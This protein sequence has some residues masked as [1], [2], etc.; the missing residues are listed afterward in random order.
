MFFFVFVFFFFSSRRRHTRCC[1]VTGVQTCALPIWCGALGEEV[2]AAAR[3]GRG[4]RRGAHFF[5]RPLTTCWSSGC[6]SL[7]TR[8]RTR[9]SC[10]RKKVL[11]PP[12]SFLYWYILG[13]EGESTGTRLRRAPRGCSPSTS[14]G[15]P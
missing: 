9:W 1:C 8:R 7:T 11:M 14:K 3:G 10:T 13:N 5:G 4:D 2:G 12:S 15:C 6:R